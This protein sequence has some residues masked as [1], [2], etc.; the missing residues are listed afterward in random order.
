M[1]PLSITAAVVSFVDIARR[2]KDSVDKVGQTRQNLQQF[3]E[4][5]VEELTELQILC[6]DGQGRLNHI[7]T[8]SIRSLQ[9][10]H[11]DL[12]NVLELCLNLAERRRSKKSFS[13]VKYFVVAW[14][15]NAEIEDHILRLRD[16]VSSVHRRFTMVASLRAERA[17][18]DLLVAT[19]EMRV[20]VNRMESLLS[21]LFIASHASGTYPA[22]ALDHDSPNGFD[23]QFLHMK[24]RRTADLLGRISA[25][26]TFLIEEHRG[27]ISFEYRGDCKLSQATLMRSAT[28][29]ALETLELLELKPSDLALHEGADHLLYLC[30][31][32]LHLGLKE[33]AAAIFIGIINIYQR[34]MQRNLGTYLPYVVWGLVRLSWHGLGTAEGL[35]AAKRAVDI[36]REAAAMMGEDCSTHLISSLRTYSCQLVVNDQFDEALTYAAE[37]LEVHRNAPTVRQDSDG[38]TICWEASGEEHVAFSSA[39]TIS[40][41][42]QMAIDNVYTLAI[43]ANVLR[44]MV[45]CGRADTGSFTWIMINP[46]LA[47]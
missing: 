22:S 9:K 20:T 16:R 28:I 39:R 18:N 5:L 34:L 45:Y 23:Y 4:N 14:L 38:L 42:Y 37:A 11:S 8:D 13:S 35:D 47:I 46:P 1:D 17:D 3:T 29:C 10:L 25:T 30:I 24:V 15:K 12:V 6:Q 44:R 7:D 31:S 19:S 32:L 33:D 2:I 40:R 26:Y 41:P 27:P 36:C 21:P 43:Y